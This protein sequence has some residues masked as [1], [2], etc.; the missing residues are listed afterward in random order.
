MLWRDANHNGIS[1]P[2][3]L[4]SAASAGIAAIDTGYKE[5]KRI[6]RNRNEFRQKGQLTWSD[7]AVAPLYDVWLQWRQ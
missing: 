3:E 2:D 6:D 1:E 5:K 4:A 7:G